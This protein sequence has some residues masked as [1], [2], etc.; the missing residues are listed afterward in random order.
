MENLT[1]IEILWQGPTSE[2]DIKRLNTGKD[3]GLY[4]IYGT[5]NIFGANIL[6]YIGQANDQT[7][8]TRIAQHKWLELGYS[9]T[10]FFFGRL[11]GVKKINNEEWAKN[12]DIAERLLI[13]YCS[14]PYNTKNL[15][16][17]GEDI[18]QIIV[19]NFGKKNVLP[20]EVSTLYHE[21]A[22]FERGKNWKE[23]S[24]K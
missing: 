2:S 11:G 15:Y 9:G 4:Q 10:Q 21:S 5:H 22:F 1:I 13:Y 24:L 16:D 14:P 17:Y 19:L 8:A 3:Y 23:Y 7:F 12:I 18:K 20:L 6:L